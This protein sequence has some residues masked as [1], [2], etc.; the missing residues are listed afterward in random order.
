[1]R[2]WT[3]RNRSFLQGFTLALALVG[4]TIG[5]IGTARRLPRLRVGGRRRKDT[6]N[7][8]IDGVIPP[9]QPVLDVLPQ[10]EVSSAEKSRLASE[11]VDMPAVSQRW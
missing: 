11:A 9:T 10:H 3:S 7:V 2:R 4:V 6:E 1:M 5:T 8:R